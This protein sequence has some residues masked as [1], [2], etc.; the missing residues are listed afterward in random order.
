AHLGRP[1][2]LLAGGSRDLPERQQTLRRTLAWSCDLLDAEELV[3]FR[4]LAVFAGGATLEAIERVCPGDGI[5]P[6]RILDILTRL[7]DHS[8]VQVG[9][10]G[11]E[12]RYRLLE[13]T[14]DYAREQLQEAGETDVLRRRHY[15]WCL[16][17]AEQAEP[18]LVGEHQQPWLA[19]LERELDNLRTTLAWCRQ[20]RAEMGL[21]LAVALVP[22]WERR[23]VFA[24]GRRVLEGLLAATPEQAP[25][26][27]R[28]LFGAGVL[29]AAQGDWPCA[30]ALLQESLAR[31]RQS[32]DR[33]TTPW[34]LLRLGDVAMADNDLEVVQ[35]CYA[36]SLNMFQEMGDV[37]GVAW[38]RYYAGFLS[39]MHAD[40]PQVVALWKQSLAGFRAVGDLRGV[41]AALSC[42]AQVALLQA[43]YANARTL[44][45]ESLVLERA[46]GNKPAIA[47][48]LSVLGNLARIQGNVG[49][50]LLLLDE[51]LALY[52]DLGDQRKRGVVLHHLGNAAL[53]SGDLAGARSRYAI[54]L[55]L[56]RATKDLRNVAR[57][58]GDMASLSDLEGDSEQTCALWQESLV[59]FQGSGTNRWGMGWTLSN[60]GILAIRWG[61]G[62][63]GVQ[64]MAAADAIHPGIRSAIDPDERA[65]WDG[66]LL[67]ARATLDEDAFRA[68]WETGHGMSAAS[69]VAHALGIRR[70]RAGA[71]VRRTGPET[72]Q[73]Q[74]TPRELEVAALVARGYTSR[75]IARTLVIAEGTASLHVEHI[76]GKLGF[77][78]RA[79]IATWA[80]SHG[81]TKGRAD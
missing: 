2:D 48:T 25:L 68:A 71:P 24:G 65:A 12:P 61:H 51:S 27:A 33:G 23:G 14:S 29:A 41:G 66:A 54:S 36:E 46:G 10:A 3:L 44:L 1:L 15:D 5:G 8:L 20:C 43:D 49:E 60:I 78:S 26:R 37:R 80:V 62:A 56:Y 81:L 21:R 13:T 32:G 28:A 50:A 34:A 39:R 18:Q 64:L 45:Q 31:C 69:A 76:R 58:L 70:P 7:V 57:V 42:L 6:E 52:E 17:L 55:S 63:G 38:A 35:A 72:P 53:D 19:R 77:H 79:K 4:R 30:R 74:L 67:A 40:Y 16:A 22:F 9:L 73:V 59:G 47:G 75:Q 11:E